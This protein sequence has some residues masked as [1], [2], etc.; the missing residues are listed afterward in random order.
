MTFILFIILHLLLSFAFTTT[1]FRRQAHVTPKSYLSFMN[2]YK[3]VY[4]AQKSEIDGLAHRMNIGL[5]KLMEASRSVGELSKELA[6]K[7]KELAVASVKAD[8]VLKEVTQKA[9]AAEKVKSQVQVVKD[10][11]QS[12][13]DVIGVKI[14]LR[15]YQVIV[16]L[17]ILVYWCN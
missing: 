17:Y 14:L 5:D 15:I 2:S 12:I 4:A 3:Q 13:V 11:A 8:T 6:V 7:E 9:H 1:R 10:R 16:C